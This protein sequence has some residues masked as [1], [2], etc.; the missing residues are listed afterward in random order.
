MP[1]HLFTKEN[2]R[3][4]NVKGNAAKRAKKEARMHLEEKMAI[5]TAKIH[6]MTV[7]SERI[8]AQRLI[9]V[10]KQLDLVDS[11]IEEE[12]CK[13]GGIDKDGKPMPACDGQLLNWLCSAQERLA[14]QERQLSGRPLPG[15]LR[16]DKPKSKPAQLPPAPDTPS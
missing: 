13:Q 16:P 7:N 5:L 2:A 14:E 6:E 8:N 3:E 10:R 11:R 4:M 12:A 15:T 1:A 9:R